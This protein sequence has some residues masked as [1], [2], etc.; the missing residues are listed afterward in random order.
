MLDGKKVAVNRHKAFEQTDDSLEEYRKLPNACVD[1]LKVKH[2][3]PTYK[4]RDRVMPGAIFR[5][6]GKKKVMTASKGL[7]NG[8]PDYYIFAD[9]TKAAPKKCELIA[10]NQGLCFTE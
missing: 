2:I 8:K 10:H 7:H 5:V 9:G 4:R 1:R 3:P 6:N